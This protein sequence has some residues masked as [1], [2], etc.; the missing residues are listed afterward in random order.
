MQCW[1]IKMYGLKCSLWPPL[2]STIAL[3]AILGVLSCAS[4]K[5]SATTP[6]PEVSANKVKCQTECPSDTKY[7]GDPPLEP[8]LPSGYV[9]IAPESFETSTKIFAQTA[10]V[11]SGVLKEVR[12]TYD[13][14]AGPRTHYIF[15][16]ATTLIGTPI[17][18]E[19]TLKSFGGP[20]PNGRWMAW[21]EGQGLALHS[22]YIVFLRNTDWT[23]SPILGDLAYRIERVAGREVLVNSTG[24]AVVGWGGTGPI[25]SAV[26]VS[27]AVGDRLHGYR[28][29]NSRAKTD[30]PSYLSSPVTGQFK[31]ASEALIPNAQR[32]E[33]PQSL[34]GTPTAAEIQRSG[35]FDRPSLST[36]TLGNERTLSADQFVALIVQAAK[37]DHIDVGGRLT[38]EPY[39]KCWSVTSTLRPRPLGRAP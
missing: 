13:P 18:G 28:D 35:M 30:R 15:E 10:I 34:P 11:F 4:Y 32:P 26:V 31:P 17:R 20:T 33:E 6:V 23:Y 16:E 25:L 21:S 9:K 22:R 5:E 12:F 19:L 7:S 8:R 24:R 36:D 38:L 29:A 27:G 39:W 14:C 2:R 1:V 37:R 3:C